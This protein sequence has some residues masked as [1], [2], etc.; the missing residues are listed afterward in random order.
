MSVSYQEVM[1][2]WDINEVLTANEW[3]DMIEDAEWSSYE[4]AR[5]KSKQGTRGR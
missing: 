5:R 4:D 2:Y 3:L 1:T